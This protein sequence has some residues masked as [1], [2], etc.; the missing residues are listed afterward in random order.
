MILDEP[1][2]SK[3]IYST[4]SKYTIIQMDDEKNDEETLKRPNVSDLSELVRVIVKRGNF[5]HMN[6]NTGNSALHAL[7]PT[8]PRTPQAQV[9]WQQR[10]RTKLDFLRVM[11]KANV[12][13]LKVPTKKKTH[14]VMPSFH[15]FSTYRNYN[16]LLRL[17]CLPPQ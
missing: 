14:T 17:S 9:S 8:Q 15:D 16:H 1:F 5:G 3:K 12:S 2:K 4:M 13:Q 11:K 6:M 7:K 10:E